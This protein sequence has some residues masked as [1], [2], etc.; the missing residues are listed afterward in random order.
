MRLI[1]PRP[2]THSGHRV[3]TGARGT[4]A[5]VLGLGSA[6]AGCQH[7]AEAVCHRTTP[8]VPGDTMTARRHRLRSA[9][10]ARKDTH[11]RRL[12]VVMMHCG[13]EIVHDLCFY[14]GRPVNIART[15]MFSMT[16]YQHAMVFNACHCTLNNLN[17][18]CILTFVCAARI[19]W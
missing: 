1:Y 7:T 2:P 8:A 15:R 12:D 16:V 10:D 17:C 11:A 19:A 6:R 18:N 5:A 13:I 9:T 4:R 14:W 3:P